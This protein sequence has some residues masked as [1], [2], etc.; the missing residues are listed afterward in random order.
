[1]PADGSA[2]RAPLDA[3]AARAALTAYEATKARLLDAA[4]AHKAAEAAHDA[5]SRALAD[6]VGGQGELLFGDS[7]VMVHSA[8]D[9][10]VKVSMRRIR[11]VA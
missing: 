9:K 1:M 10:P 4:A 5:A 3:A 8:G 11:V 6:V 2:L 7:L